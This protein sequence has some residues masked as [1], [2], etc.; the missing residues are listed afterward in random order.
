MSVV[1]GV[2]STLKR[3][4]GD[5]DT[6]WRLYLQKRTSRHWFAV[7]LSFKYRPTVLF[8]SVVDTIF[9]LNKHDVILQQLV[10]S[11]N[12]LIYKLLQAKS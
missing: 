6:L 2:V 11:N 4:L 7:T 9:L 8:Q 10:V 1:A 12:L 5:G 3:W